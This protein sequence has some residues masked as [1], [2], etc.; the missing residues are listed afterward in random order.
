[1]FTDYGIAPASVRKLGRPVS[2][3]AVI[4]AAFSCPAYAQDATEAA[5]ANPEEE[6]GLGEII[7][8]AQKRA[9]NSQDTPISISVLGEAALEQQ[10]ISGFQDL[11][12]GAIPALRIAPT[13]GRPSALAITMRGI[14][15][16]DPTSISR[17]TAIG[18][19]VD[20]VYLGR[21]QGLGT[22][23]FDLERI[24]VLR[25]PQGTL[26]G[27]NAVGGALNI[28]SKRPTGEFGVE[29]KA[30]LRNY[31]GRAWEAH[32]NLP[33]FAGISVKLDGVVSRR[34]G[35]VDNPLAGAWDWGQYRK[36]GFRG[37][38]EWEPAENV[39]LLYSFDTSRDRSTPMYMHFQ[40]RIPGVVPALPPIFDFEPH[41]VDR[42]RLGVPLAP[43][44]AKVSG[45][46]LTATWDVN[47]SLTLR[48]ITAYRE[49]SQT[50]DD[51]DI[52]HQ[53]GYR[54]N[55]NFA[56]NSTA[57]VDQ[58][59]F[60]QELQLVGDTARLK[61]VT[62]AFYFDEDASDSAYAPFLYRWNATGT[63]FTV[64][65]PPVGGAPPD[66]A[67]VNHVI[68]RALFGQA[69]WTPPIF[70]DRLHLTAG[71]RYTQDR[72]RGAITLIRG[73]PSPLTYT[74]RSN[75]LDPTFT[76][77]YDISDDINAYAKY[78][79]AYRSGGAQS[80][81]PTFR[82]FGEEEV[83]AWE[84]G[85]KSE[86][87]DRRARLNIAAYTMDYRNLQ[88]GFSVPGNPSASDTINTDVPARI[89]GIEVDLTVAPVERL[90]LAG[91]YSYTDAKIPPQVHPFTGATTLVSA[92]FTPDHAA[93]IMADYSIPL[94]AMDL[95]LHADAN[96]SSPFT[97][98]ASTFVESHAYFL[99]N[100]RAT[101]ADIP[102]DSG[103]LS[104][105]LW[106]KNLFNEEFETFR[107]DFA[108]AGLSNTRTAVF[109][110]PRTFGVEA[111]LVF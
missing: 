46:G 45:H 41:R 86:F 85:F 88:I 110:E 31:D 70:G 105:A 32:V 63:A 100:A 66:R 43:S 53:I 15:S 17:D 77:A 28:I 97:T 51:N 102:I 79:V 13:A 16:G 96:Y 92:P 98:A 7:V 24:E 40:Q 27:R 81:S 60:S 1:M 56:R 11:V 34:D 19:Y 52:G 21:V 99:V 74:F 71:A 14:A 82:P 111:K 90:T 44:V 22:E 94:G 61:Y 73:L 33:S 18:I 87:L 35:L 20:G 26:F 25:G 55:G 29:V 57:R 78:N 109:N 9:E 38:A 62:G 75:R 58:D 69:T 39:N 65:N 10:G 8:T 59:Q 64:N 4:A 72:K 3:L 108:G 6:A 23:L 12:N 76:A 84:I 89:R 107:F 37:L 95:L 54:P 36:E 42:A 104:V 48:S 47:D 106:G 30:G 68:S 101:L 83:Q 93:S 80:R 49:L 2:A 50:Q 67:S 91:S 5:Q 103:V